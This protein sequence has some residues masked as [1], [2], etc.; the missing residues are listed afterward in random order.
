MATDH[1]VDL[2]D[3][4]D[5]LQNA[6][7]DDLAAVRQRAAELPSYDLVD[8]VER[9]P[10]ADAAVL[11]RALEKDRALAVFEDLDAGHQADLL[12]G[13]RDA[14]VT[15]LFSDLDADD[16]ADLLDELPASVAARLLAGLGPE[17]RRR[18]SAILGYPKRSIGR[19]M[20]SRITRVRADESAAGVQARIRARGDAAGEIDV[21]PVTDTSRR[22]LGAVTLRDLFLAEG[23]VLLASL[24]Q[25]DPF[26]A[27]ATDDAETVARRFIDT[28]ELA[29][30]VVDTENRLVGMVGIDEALTVVEEA[31][32]E[33]AARAGAHEPLR[34]PY[35]LT[36]VRRI[37]TSRIVWLLVLAVSAILTIQ[38]LEVFEATLAE[39]VLLA[40]F[41][42]LLTGTAGN[43]GNQA[44]T[45]ITRALA[46]GDIR[47]RDIGR[48]MGREALVGL[49]LG[50]ALGLLGF[51]LAGLAYGP[52]IGLV[53]GSTLVIVCTLAAT[54]GS[55]MPIVGKTVGA[56]P[57][58]FSN[59]FISTFCDATSLIVYFLIAKAVLGI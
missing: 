56:D 33:D 39:V 16:Q 49:G 28:K 21:L 55:V 35:L 46:L 17:D 10:L 20:T 36:P 23:D 3:V 43:T 4:E 13:L 26:H 57:A 48:V 18:T 51:T 42:P 53:I 19:R 50:S 52:H 25:T 47:K 15:G 34:R 44:A 14:T 58:V 11:F 32:T 7:P 29:F 37:I 9:L 6:S 24:M 27:K 5:L 8:L 2:R 38:V 30:P 54:V 40:V 22:L 41:I 12:T 1:A 31:D 45:T 59:P